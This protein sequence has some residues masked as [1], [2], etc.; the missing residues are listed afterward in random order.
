[1]PSDRRQPARRRTS[2]RKGGKGRGPERPAPDPERH[3]RLN[4]SREL[5]ATLDRFG[6]RPQKGRGQNFL[7]DPFALGQILEAAELGTDDEVLEIGP[8]L[9]VLTKALAQ[10]VRRVVAVEI[11]KGM[12]GA[13][14]ETLADRPN[15]EVVE[16]DALQLDPVEQFAERPY[17]IVANLPYYI[18]SRLLRHYFES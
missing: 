1:M 11:D 4:P 12:V 18:T 17:K 7:V 3:T 14:A 6:L 16:G 10:R 5:R 9:G 2:I 15:V 8:G 13:L